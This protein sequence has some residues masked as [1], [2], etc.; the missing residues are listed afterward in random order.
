MTPPLISFPT[1]SMASL[2]EA[3]VND[4][5]DDVVFFVDALLHGG[6]SFGVCVCVWVGGWV[7][8]LVWGVVV[9][10]AVVDGRKTSLCACCFTYARLRHC[11]ACKRAPWSAVRMG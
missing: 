8:L 6:F 5:N 7:F 11:R 2:S 1:A 3:I 9:A 4:D 10:A